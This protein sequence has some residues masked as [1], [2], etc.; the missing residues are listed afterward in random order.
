MM[1]ALNARGKKGTDAL[2]SLYQVSPLRDFSRLGKTIR[3]LPPCPW[4]WW[5]HAVPLSRLR[6]IPTLWLDLSSTHVDWEMR[7]EDGRHSTSEQNFHKWLCFGSASC[8]F[9]VP[10]GQ[11]SFRDLGAG[12]AVGPPLLTDMSKKQKC[13]LL[14]GWGFGV[15]PAAKLTNTENILYFQSESWKY[16]GALHCHF[17][18]ISVLVLDSVNY[19]DYATEELQLFPAIWM[20]TDSKETFQEIVLAGAPG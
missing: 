6:Y 14:Q 5:G 3:I 8:P 18:W 16:N 11:L 10:W 13:L 12:T 9:S 1:S 4:L 7:E 2:G 15:I 19:L 20:C 17:T